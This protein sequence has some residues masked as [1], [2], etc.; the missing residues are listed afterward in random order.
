MNDVFELPCYLNGQFSPIAEAKVSVL[1][2][3]FIF[4]DGVYEV[5]PAYRGRPFRLK[6]HLARMNR[7]LAEIRLPNPL[8]EAAWIALISDL[9]LRY[10]QHMQT[11][12]SE[13]DQLVYI[14]ITRGV[15]PRDHVMPSHPVPTVFAMSN[16]LK[17]ASAMD[18]AL[19]VACTSAVDFRW[20][21][22]HIKSTS[23][24]GSVLARQIS[25]DEGTAET[26][27]F[28]DGFLSEA[29]ASN[30]WVV[31]DGVLMGPPKDNLVLQGI[32]YDLLAE[33]CASAGI[34]YQLGPITEAEVRAA[35]E[36]LLS[37]ATKE[38]LPVR[39]LD[40]RPI[41]SG[42]PGP[43]YHALYAAYQTAK[44]DNH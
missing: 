31:R 34:A 43:V 37:S 3:G 13:T 1:D 32:R 38:V 15:A 19:G 24:L 20:Q 26:I 28:K 44:A 41:G 30:V 36:V 11:A 16:M 27:M 7:S 29:A 4:G 35:D 17:P 21:K 23:L 18:R 5:V 39:Q 9:L 42:A 2:R 25:A 6:Q 22:A 12:V 40:G 33:L 10:A 8:S 14:Q